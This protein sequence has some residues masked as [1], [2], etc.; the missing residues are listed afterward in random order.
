MLERDGIGVVFLCKNMAKNYIVR[1]HLLYAMAEN[2]VPLSVCVY[3]F[4][5]KG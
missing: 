1:K 3:D 2:S 5:V 4:A